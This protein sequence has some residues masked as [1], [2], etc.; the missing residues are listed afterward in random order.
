MRRGYVCVFLFK[1]TIM[2]YVYCVIFLN[3]SLAIVMLELNISQA[4]I[5]IKRSVKLSSS[6]F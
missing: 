3:N 2:V 1:G 4:Q 5:S 6:S